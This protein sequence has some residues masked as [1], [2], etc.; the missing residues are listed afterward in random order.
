MIKL[1]SFFPIAPPWPDAILYDSVARDFLSTGIFRY[2]VWGEFDPTYLAANFNNGPL[3][4]A[5]H[6]L[7]LTLFGTTD[8]RLMMAV[9]CIFLLLSTLNIAHVLRLSS[10]QR[11]LTVLVLCNPL[12]LNYVG[13]IR[14][15]F[16]NLFFITCIW[17]LLAP[18]SGILN[19]TR[20]VGAGIVLGLAALTHQ[21]AVFFIPPSLYLIIRRGNGL[22]DTIK[23]MIILGFSCLLIFTPYLY[24]VWHHWTDFSFQLLHNQIGESVSGGIWPFVRSF[25][26]PL[27]YPSIAQFT[28]TGIVPRWLADGVHLSLIFMLAALI[29]RWRRRALLSPT[30]WDAL[31][32]WFMLNLGCAVTTF[33]VFVTFFFAV[34]TIALLRDVYP[35]IPKA[36]RNALCVGALLGLSQQLVMGHLLR[37]RLFYWE[38]YQIASACLSDALP[39][40]ARVY[41]MAYPDPSVQLSNWRP[42]LDIRRYIDFTKYQTEWQKIVKTNTYFIT[43]GDENFLTRFDHGSALRDEIKS[44]HVLPTECT[45]EKLRFTLYSRH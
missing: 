34:A 37:A 13:I 9:N 41:V 30:T 1:L 14:P 35:D 39:Q 5:L 20:I 6:A 10:R 2:K 38:E 32:I 43:S 45:S 7:I 12:V 17:R 42:D 8:S 25:M 27:F 33:S 24:Y 18:L 4:P 11:M 28:L 15:E 23:K 29:G 40:N 3:Y 31:V 36:L 21:F 22:T 26:T 44:S 16:L 19:S